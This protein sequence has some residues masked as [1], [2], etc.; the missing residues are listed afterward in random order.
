MRN[1]K[2]TSLE[3]MYVERSEQNSEYTLTRRDLILNIRSIDLTPYELLLFTR[4]A[5]LL[6]VSTVCLLL[7]GGTS[8]FHSISKGTITA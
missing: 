8:L 1:F 4:S 3:S 5:N 7:S 6:A 2:L